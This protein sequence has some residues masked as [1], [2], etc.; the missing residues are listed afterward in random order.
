MYE[1]RHSFVS[2]VKQLPA[3]EV[4]DL[5]GHSA[6]MDTFG[7]Y[8]HIMEGDSARTAEEVNAIFAKLIITA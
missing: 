5:V 7:Q 2:A 6:D 4:K 1:L 3:G 8:S